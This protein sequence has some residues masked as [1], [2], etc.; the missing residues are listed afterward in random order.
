MRLQHW[1]L[2][3]TYRTRYVRQFLNL[4]CGKCSAFSKTVMR[5][6]ENAVRYPVSWLKH[7]AQ[8]TLP[9]K[10]WGLNSTTE[11]VAE[12]KLPNLCLQCDLSSQ[13]VFQCPPSSVTVHA[14]WSG[15]PYLE[16]AIPNTHFF[17]WVVLIDLQFY[18]FQGHS[19][20]LLC[21]ICELRVL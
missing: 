18:L 2:C 1:H 16:R 6:K 21:S 7:S 20:K 14:G 13:R 3:D 8:N 17:F 4:S 5:N 9:L 15:T 10:P 11:S 12:K 19:L